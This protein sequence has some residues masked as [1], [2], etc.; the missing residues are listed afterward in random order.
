MINPNETVSEADLH[1]YI[2]EQLTP[3]RR[4][5]VEDYLSRNPEL[6]A[7]VMADLRGRDELRLAMAERTPVIKLATQ[8]AASRLERG[9][10]RGMY[11]AKFRRAAAVA[12]FVGMG[13]LAHVEFTSVGN[14][15]TASASAMP[16]YV[17]EATRAHRTALLRASMHSQ[18]V[19]PNYDR[20][21]IRSMTSINMPD[22][23]QGW[24]VLDVQIFPA[25]SGPAVEMA[26]KAE[27][28]GTLSL[29]AVRPGR[30]NVMPATVTSGNEVTAAYWQTGD[31]AY[32]LVGTAESKALNEAAAR[33]AATLY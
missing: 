33:L 20:D 5:V 16:A 13:W 14:W 28:L 21:E 19:Q 8:D 26:I 3:A 10:V 25:S 31:V 11:F 2:D 12:V 1:A 15:P 17:G 29:F 7:R 23:P 4:I 18:P 30:F 22:L 27:S 6:A 9:L 32:A 24:A